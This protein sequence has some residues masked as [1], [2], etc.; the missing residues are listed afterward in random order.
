M[1]NFLL[2]CSLLVTLGA[3]SAFALSISVYDSTSQQADI[4]NWISNQGAQVTVLEDFEGKTAGWYKNLHTGVGTFTAGDTKG[5][6]DTSYNADNN[7][8]YSSDPYFSIQNR[9]QDW[10]GR[11]NTTT[12][13]SK[14]LDSGD[15]TELTL[16]NIDSSLRNLFFYLQDPSDINA[17]TTI[18]VNDDLKYQLFPKQANG[19]SYFVGITLEDYEMLS[20]VTWTTS[21]A[22]DGYGL[23]SFSTVSVSPVPEPATFLLFGAGVVGL[24]GFRLSKKKKK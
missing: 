13:G 12:D 10:Y 23:D 11:Y 7:N 15:I 24:V 18:S 16:N 9:E 3:S 4:N 14:W 17:T 1:T 20:Q 19:K 5:L 6:G 2:L 21:S 8:L 22:N